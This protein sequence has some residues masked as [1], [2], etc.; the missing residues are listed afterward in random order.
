MWP[1]QTDTQ[2]ITTSY[3]WRR[4]LNLRRKEENSTRPESE[5]RERWTT[6]KKEEKERVEQERMRLFWFDFIHIH[7]A[8]NTQQWIHRWPKQPKSCRRRLCI[9]FF[10]LFFFC[11]SHSRHAVHWRWLGW[12]WTSSSVVGFYTAEESENERIDDGEEKGTA[13]KNWRTS[14][15]ARTVV[16]RGSRTRSQ[17][18]RV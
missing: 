1:Q 15:A 5:E 14:T 4:T 2:K 10:P 9:S 11:C 12:L 13:S 3:H 6:T 16:L 8:N 7:S 18:G 17:P